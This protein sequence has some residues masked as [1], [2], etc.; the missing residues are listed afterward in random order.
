V[1]RF[2]QWSRGTRGAVV[3]AAYA[4]AMDNDDSREIANIV[5][6]FAE[7]LDSHD[8]AAVADLFSDMTY[9]SPG[10]DYE[11]S[12]NADL[13]VFYERVLTEMNER[14]AGDP[15]DALTVGHKHVFTNLII[16]IDEARTTATCRYYG[17]VFGFS[18]IKPF[19]PRWSGRY[20]DRFERRG[21]RWRIVERL[22]VTD[23]P[24]QY[25]PADSAR[26]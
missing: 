11:V 12:G 10:I 1:D 16:E 15:D 20:Y 23:Y 9:K 14:W 26:P 5:A 19:Q 18:D 8:Y 3:P 25:R 24:R 7:H 4:P 6:S 2:V 17:T 13:A 21:D 22:Q